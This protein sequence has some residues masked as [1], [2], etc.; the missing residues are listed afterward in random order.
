MRVAQIG[1]GFVGNALHKSTINSGMKAYRSIT[2]D[3][4]ILEFSGGFNDLHTK[5]Y[6][7]ILNGSG[8][9]IIDAEPSIRIVIEIAKWSK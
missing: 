2:I 4:N 5:S 1:N 7:E 9:G 3:G 6:S 8:Y